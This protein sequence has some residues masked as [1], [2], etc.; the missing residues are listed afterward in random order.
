MPLPPPAAPA[1]AA[2]APAVPATVAV[3]EKK[4]PQPAPIPEPLPPGTPGPTVVTT[5]GET[6]ALVPVTG[7]TAGM[8]HYSLAHPRGLLVNLPEARSALPLGV[9]AVGRDGLRFVWIRE[10]REGGLQVRFVF[11]KPPPDERLLEL[12]E[13]AVK[14][15][16]RL[17]ASPMAQSLPQAPVVPPK[18][19]LASGQ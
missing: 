4:R 10:R 1:P 6:T 15:R 14:I 7:S 9:H 17:H 12:E 8:F 18:D 13:A 2:A 3:E 19:D 16:V 5:D 11:T